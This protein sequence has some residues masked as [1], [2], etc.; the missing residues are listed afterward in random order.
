MTK[1]A[2]TATPTTCRCTASVR[3]RQLSLESFRNVYGFEWYVRNGPPSVLDT[4][5]DDW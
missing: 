5:I 4:L 2:S 1:A 3:P